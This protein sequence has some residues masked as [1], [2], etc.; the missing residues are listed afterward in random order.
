M[1][2]LSSLVVVSIG[3]VAMAAGSAHAQ[4][5]VA[6]QL[7]RDGKR[8]MT[9]GKIAEACTAFEGSYRKDAA[10]T[11]LLNLADCREKNGQFASAWGHFID[12]ERETRGNAAVASF[13]S[14]AK[15]RAGRLE[16]RLS[17]LIINV[18]DEARV[19]GLEITR[20]G[21]PV[22][23]AEWNRD[24]PVDGGV[25]KI[26]GKAPAYEAWSTEVTVGKEKDKQSVNVPRFRELPEDQVKPP[27][28]P[29]PLV[30]GPA[31]SSFTGKRKAA[32]GVGAVGVIGLAAGTV[33]YFQAKG[34]HD[35]A[36]DATT[37]DERDRLEDDAN[38][39]YLI[40][41][42]GWGVG[43]AAVGAAAFLWITGGPSASG[44]S[45]EQTGVIL[46]PHV[47]GRSAGFALSGRF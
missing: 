2:T 35:D 26:A 12:A 1:R 29:Q 18:P 44:E 21:Q 32:V 27:V 31:P 10:V 47:D 37:Q 23:A 38:G 34:L 33:L 5:N 41:Q 25:W 43:A 45:A 15:D 19:D 22:D 7:F 9:E 4:S 30:T 40:A 8:L 28:G 6:E 36:A 46:T 13:N 11:T 42:I 20:N 14:T 24:I 39:K 17:Y 3:L 16:G